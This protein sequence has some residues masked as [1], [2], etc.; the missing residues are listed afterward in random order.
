MA[1][2]RPWIQNSF[3]AP[4]S[5]YSR[6]VSVLVSKGTPFVVLSVH[7]DREGCFVVL[8]AKLMDTVMTIVG[9]YVPPPFSTGVLDR[10]M[11]KVLACPPAPILLLGD[12][13][14]V[15]DTA[16]DRMGKNPGP[17]TQ[18][19]NW[20]EA[21]GLQ[22]LWR[23]KHPADRA[24]SCH[25]VAHKSLSRIDLAFSTPDFLT[26]V[27]AYDIRRFQQHLSGFNRWE[28]RK[29][30][31]HYFSDLEHVLNSLGCITFLSEMTSR[32]TLREASLES[33]LM[34]HY[35]TLEKQW[36]TLAFAS[37]FLQDVRGM[38]EEVMM[39][40]WES[41]F[42]LQRDHP[43]PNL[44]GMVEEIKKQGHFLVEQIILDRNGHQLAPSMEVIQALHKQNLQEKTEKMV[45]FNAPGSPDTPGSFCISE[46]YLDLRIVASNQFR[47]QSQHELMEVGGKYEIYMQK[48]Q[49]GLEHI[50][51]DKLFRWCH[52]SGSTPHAVVVSGVPG[53]G[54]TTLMQ[55]FVYDWI[56]GKHYQRFTF[57]L[58]FKFRDFNVSKKVSLES[59]IRDEFRHLGG[60]LCS[61]LQ[62][63][64]RLLFIFDGLDESVHQIDFTTNLLTRDTQIFLD[65]GVIVASLVQQTLLKGCSV[66]ITSRPTRLT[67]IDIGVFKRVCEIMGFFPQERERYFED[68]FKDA[69]LAKKAFH[70]VRENDTL[71]TFCYIPS[72]CW[73]TCTVLS[74]CLQA[75]KLSDQP[76][77]VT[78]L[79][80]IFISHILSNH[81]QNRDG[82]LKLLRSIGQLAEYG[83]LNQKLFF[84]SEEL[85]IFNQVSN[86]QLLSSFFVES[87]QPS[88]T[89]YSY[90]HLTIQEFVG[91][92]PHF[93]AYLCDDLQKLLENASGYR[94]GRGD[95]LL[96]FLIGLSDT[97]TMG[98]LKPY[99]GPLSIEASKHIIGWLRKFAHSA[100][101][102]EH[103]DK[104]EIL[105]LFAFLFE[106]RNGQL[107][108]EAFGLNMRF[109]LTEHHLTSLDC[110]M[111]SFI[112]GS[113]REIE[114]LDLDTC[115]IHSEGLRRLTPVLSKIKDVRWP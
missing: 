96:R 105:K 59:M 87:K 5:A 58:F 18:L 39:G 76:K 37:A 40:L 26:R 115:Y 109:D 28:I 88:G 102:K 100:W 62:D 41:L 6:G 36:G 23:R 10:I 84:D 51:P 13:N 108:S 66:L 94:D 38:R 24:Y 47:K 79:F 31:E 85:E 75:G 34:E 114:C 97:G 107:V 44:L 90:I 101:K 110:T 35:I 54:K 4:F 99:L 81:S 82:A 92:L 7:T 12:F 42:V 21:L 93:I 74:K 20:A 57:V 52:R 11:E 22:E 89:T 73:I 112:L 83:V 80:A 43:H 77:T 91:A 61:I 33:S 14:M 106:S 27:A 78:Q 45:E 15:L 70:Y 49:S 104:R 48:K 46:R 86:R 95:M 67:A 71:Y 98:I 1:L 72:Y 65:L 30:Y 53:V 111:L 16:L 55:K 69:Q 64:E 8:H 9:V 32:M 2:K 25:S 63:P 60:S 68:C 29:I 103:E 56:N 50:T 3:H 17:K 19:A 113:C